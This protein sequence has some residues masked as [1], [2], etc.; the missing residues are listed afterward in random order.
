MPPA[1]VP[2]VEVVDGVAPPL[3]TMSMQNAE[4]PA[5]SNGGTA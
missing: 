5:D 2:T 4:L 1:E 3:T